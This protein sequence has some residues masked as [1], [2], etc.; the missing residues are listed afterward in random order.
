MRVAG[1]AATASA[2]KQCAFLAVRVLEVADGSSGLRQLQD[3]LADLTL[4]FRL[5]RI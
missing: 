1:T 4:E 5:E 2:R 3:A